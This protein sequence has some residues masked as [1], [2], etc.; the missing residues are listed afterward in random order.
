M[1][2]MAQWKRTESGGYTAETP[3]GNDIAITKHGKSWRMVFRGRGHDERNEYATRGAAMA[4][5]ADICQREQDE[6]NALPGGGCG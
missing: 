1:T 6:I 4:D 3:A 5:A 2:T